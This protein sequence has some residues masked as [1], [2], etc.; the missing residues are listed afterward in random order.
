MHYE[1]VRT[2]N[3]LY[4]ITINISVIS[5][6][7]GKPFY[8]YFFK[9]TRFRSLTVTA[10]CYSTTT[11][12]FFLSRLT[13]YARAHLSLSSSHVRIIE[14]ITIYKYAH[15]SIGNRSAHK[16]RSLRVYTVFLLLLF[17]FFFFH[18]STQK[19]K[20]QS[21]CVIGSVGR[22][23]VKDTHPRVHRWFFCASC[24]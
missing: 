5:F 16:E 24:K 15:L 7:Y 17:G 14:F 13:E 2:R 1:D 6:K 9:K 4:R 22:W 19:R 20:Q 3:D 21:I 11:Q 10:T 18:R 23:T 12:S 8:Y